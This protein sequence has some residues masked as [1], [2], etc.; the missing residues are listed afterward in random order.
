MPHDPL[1]NFAHN[2]PQ[3][4]SWQSNVSIRGSLQTFCVAPDQVALAEV[5][6]QL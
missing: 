6:K 5:P 2:K 1:E 4:W 3:Q